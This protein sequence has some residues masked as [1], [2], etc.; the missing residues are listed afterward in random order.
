MRM[1]WFFCAASFF[2]LVPLGPI[3]AQE[4]PGGVTLR[5]VKYQDLKDVVLKNRG[6]VVYVDFWHNY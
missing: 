2:A 5:E 4:K 3:A 1:R 6:K